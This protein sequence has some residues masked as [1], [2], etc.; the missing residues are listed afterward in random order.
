MKCPSDPDFTGRF[1]QST[2]NPNL[3][4]MSQESEKRITNALEAYRAAKK[5]NIVFF[6]RGFNIP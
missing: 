2:I 4:I 5:P 1:S 3:Y 6:A